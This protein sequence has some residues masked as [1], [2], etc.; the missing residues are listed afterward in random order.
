MI[1][2]HA[3][4]ALKSA[5]AEYGARDVSG[6]VD[7]ALADPTIDADVTSE[8][9]VEAIRTAFG[10]TT[11]SGV[12]VFIEETSTT[13]AKVIAALEAVIAQV[14]ASNRYT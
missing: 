6:K 5:V 13:R 11:G 7:L 9:A 10:A 3:S 8:A 1:L 4:L 12:K 14:R 2:Y